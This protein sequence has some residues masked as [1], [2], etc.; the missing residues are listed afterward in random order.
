MTGPFVNGPQR[1]GVAPWVG[2]E[3]SPKLA[4]GPG[5]VGGIPRFL[6]VSPWDVN[7]IPSAINFFAKEQSN[8]IL[9]ANAGDQVVTTLAGGG[10]FK[11][12]PQ[13]IAS[14]QA[15]SMFCDTPSLTTNIR[16][17]VRANLQPIPGL[18]NIGFPPQA[19]VFINFP[20]P[21][22]FNVLYAG[23]LIDVLIERLVTDVSNQVNFTFLGWYNTG[24]DV[25]AWT[26]AQPGLV[27][28]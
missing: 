13:N 3:G 24:Q 22:P 19:A 27:T 10:S 7:P 17:T 20:I 5:A 9:G 16:Y 25:L 12:P 14:I 4:G 23:A 18:S 15:V 11:L 28:R 26:G 21:G 2:S 6:S 1:T 8:L